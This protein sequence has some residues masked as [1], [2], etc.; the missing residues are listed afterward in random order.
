[1]TTLNQ[2]LESAT[3][4]AKERALRAAIQALE[5]CARKEQAIAERVADIPLNV[6][7]FTQGI[8]RASIQRAES[9]KRSLDSIMK[10]L[11]K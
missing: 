11:E 10:H 6:T 2:I 7:A 5:S 4:E 8:A 1:M 3:P 9:I